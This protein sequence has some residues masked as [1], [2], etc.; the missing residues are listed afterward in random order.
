MAGRSGDIFISISGMIGAGKTTLARA[1]GSI[2]NLKVNIN[3]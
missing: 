2:M 3:I 1:L